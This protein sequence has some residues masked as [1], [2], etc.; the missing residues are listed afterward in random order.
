M[1]ET[2]Y[3]TPVALERH[4]TAPF[5]VERERYLKYC[6][7]HGSRYRTQRQRAGHLLWLAL[8]LQAADRQGVNSQRLRQ[9]IQAEPTPSNTYAIRTEI[10]GRC[11]LKF[12]GWWQAPQKPIPFEADLDQF[13]RWMRDERGLATSTINQWRETAATFLHWYGQTGRD[14]SLLHPDD[15]D[16]YFAT[17]GAGRWGR[18]S[19][20]YMVGMLRTFLGH[21]ATRGRCNTN[22]PAAIFGPRRYALEK[23]P[24]A[25]TWEEVRR[26][27][28]TTDTDA[29]QDIRDRAILL[30]MAVYGLRRGEVAALRLDQIH[31]QAHELHILRLKRNQAQIFPLIETVAAALARYIDTVRPAVGYTQIFIRMQAPHVPMIAPS[32]YWLVSSRLRALGLTGAKLGPHALRHACATRMLAQGLTLK[33]IGDHLGHGSPRSTLT[34]TKVDLVG[35]REVGD[36]DLGALQ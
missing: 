28:A 19:I 18:V 7:D 10:Y 25:L 26:V 8:R 12:L 23:I 15:I 17:H 16:A 14:L 24:P 2:L 9:I 4:R 32:L 1:L 3:A 5:L 35:L 33:E 31:W 13:V 22:L 20:S 27:I 11:W 21:A 6:A 30:L 36:F 34:Y 29:P